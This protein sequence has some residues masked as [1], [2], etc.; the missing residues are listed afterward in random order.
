MSNVFGKVMKPIILRHSQK[1]NFWQPSTDPVSHRQMRQMRL[2]AEPLFKAFGNNLL[3]AF[4]T[5]ASRFD[6]LSVTEFLL[7]L[8]NKNII[9]I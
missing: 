8:S 9:S 5:S 2:A 7:V 4:R 1:T 6:A 3:L